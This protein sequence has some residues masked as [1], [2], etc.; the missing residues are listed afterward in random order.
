MRATGVVWVVAVTLAVALGAGTAFAQAPVV[1]ATTVADQSDV[2][3]PE[4]PDVE[5]PEV[6]VNVEVP[7][8]EV[9]VEVPK[10]DAPKL[11]KSGKP[12][13]TKAKPA[14]PTPQPKPAQPTG[15]DAGAP[16]SAPPSEP[17]P[18]PQLDAAKSVSPR[19]KASPRVAASRIG[20]GTTGGRPTPEQSRKAARRPADAASAERSATRR[21]GS[22]R[23]SADATSASRHRLAAKPLP[24]PRLAS[25]GAA[26]GASLDRQPPRVL[27]LDAREPGNVTMLLALVLT[28]SVA[29][30]LGREVRRRPAAGSQRSRPSAALNPLRQEWQSRFWHRRDN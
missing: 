2:E 19:P 25:D 18:E 7:N 21:A 27:I 26:A 16:S 22:G 15:A 29:F 23:E 11:E 17:R 12:R 13:G 28:A 4:V 14:K 20:H 8:V 5:V 10:V 24:A 9:N 6:E 30:L 1:P 3:V